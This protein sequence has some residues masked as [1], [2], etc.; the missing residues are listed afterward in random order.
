MIEGK[1]WARALKKNGVKGQSPIF[2]CVC[3]ERKYL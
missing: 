2:R 1:L 3:V